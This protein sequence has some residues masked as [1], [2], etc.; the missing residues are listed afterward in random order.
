MLKQW[1]LFHTGLLTSDYYRFP[2][3]PYL[4]N[5]WQVRLVLPRTAFP[6]GGEVSERGTYKAKEVLIRAPNEIVAQRAANLIHSARLLLEGSASFSHILPAENAPIWPLGSEKN[7]WET[8]KKRMVWTPNVPLACLISARAS[9]KLEL[10]YALAKLRLS[11]EMCSVPFIELDP[12][13]SENIPKS[14]IPEDHVRFCFA[15]VAAWSCIEELGF[16]IRAS[17]E[18]PS[19]LRDGGWNPRIK[20]NLEERL[21]KGGV[22]LKERFY[23]ALRGPRTHIERKRSPRILEK[24]SWARYSMRDG[25]IEV[26]D[27]LDYVS[28]LRSQV[29]AHRASKLMLRVLSVYDVVNSQF[30]ARRLLLE[31][32]G[33]W[34][35][36]GKRER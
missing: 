30:L 12:H 22:N 29:A 34:R 25:K 7:E 33:F 27:A 18:N 17:R 20:S 28:F 16:E 24:A 14:P 31:K 9:R 23:W 1:Q 2:P 4:G 6:L 8:L 19:K 13:H 21:L 35:Y 5:G 10:V 3:P 36:L 26:I 32:A 11:F 15:I